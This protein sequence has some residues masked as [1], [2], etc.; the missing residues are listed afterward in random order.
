MA[1]NTENNCASLVLLF[2]TLFDDII[3]IFIQQD[4]HEDEDGDIVMDLA[5]PKPMYS[6]GISKSHH[7]S[8]ITP[9]RSLSINGGIVDV[10]RVRK[11]LLI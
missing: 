11:A 2:C 7:G 9:R 10:L 5:T 4:F 8:A 3:L 1:K 6:R